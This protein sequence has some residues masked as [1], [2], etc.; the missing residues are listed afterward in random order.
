[1]NARKFRIKA[2]KHA[3]WIAVS[4]WTGFTFAGYFTPVH[5]LAHDLVNFDLGPWQTFWVFFY[6]F[7]TYGMA[8]FM[9]EQVC[10]YMCP[11]ARF[12]SVMFDPDTLIVTYDT[13]RG[14][15]RGARAKSEDYKTA[16]KGD[17]VDC[18][19]CVQVCPTGIDIRNGL[20]YEC[21]G[22]SACVDACDQVMDKLGYERGLVRYS[23]ENALEKNFGRAEI[24]AHLIRPRVLI[25]SAVL[26][27]ITIAAAW[28][29]AV[30][31]PLK[32]DV[33]RDRGVLAREVEGGLIENVYTLRIMNTDEQPHRYS[34]G[35]SGMPG[36]EL[37]GPH[38]TEVGP[39]STQSLVVSARVQPDAGPKGSQPIR[40]D[41][42]AA[43]NPA[44]RLQEKA[45]FM[46]P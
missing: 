25:Y 16:G 26:V 35:V 45:V 13:G 20:Q 23:T 28:G 27:A 6:S 30:R 36:I 11:Y 40:F 7:A 44:I 12:Q 8:G 22:C 34:I 3:A 29:I 17:C 5:T 43:G 41:I 37:A 4:L 24:L 10:K 39:A 19:I 9:R 1:M 21:I 18:G 33:I 15:P 46:M 14:E 42:E 2:A 38:E 31:L 32:V